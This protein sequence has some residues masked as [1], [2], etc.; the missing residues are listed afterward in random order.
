MLIKVPH[1]WALIC[2]SEVPIVIALPSRQIRVGRAA[3]LGARIVVTLNIIAIFRAP[4]CFPGSDIQRDKGHIHHLE[5]AAAVLLF[6]RTLRST[7]PMWCVRE[8]LR[9]QNRAGDSVRM[10]VETL[11]RQGLRAAPARV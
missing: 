8:A 1:A 4:A 2:I 6:I 10:R 9:P 7:N 11:R 5:P 3:N